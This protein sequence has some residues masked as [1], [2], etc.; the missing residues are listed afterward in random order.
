MNRPMPLP[1][2]NALFFVAI[3]PVLW[4]LVS[5]TALPATAQN[6]AR[7][8]ELIKKAKK[9]NESTDTRLQAKLDINRA[10]ALDPSNSEAWCQKACI[11]HIMEE[12]EQALPCI[13]RCLQL[14]PQGAYSWN[15]KATILSAMGKNQEAL[16]ASERSIKLENVPDMHIT[17]ATILRNL[18]KLEQA[19]SELDAVLKVQPGEVTAHA[20]RMGVASHTHHWQKV[21][22]DSTFLI[23]LKDEKPRNVL[24]HI[25]ARAE[26]YTELKQYDKAIADYLNELKVIPGNRQ[27][28]VGLIKAYRASGNL[29]AAKEQEKVLA[30]LDED[31]Q[32]PK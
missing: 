25:L 8:E 14:K 22:A 29:K 21:V 10:I 13:D 5:T 23:G 32:M 15:L 11:L 2:R 26:A 19:E 28:H 6:K 30:E 9:E 1:L 12:D 18:G 31:Y 7:A 3:G 16:E 17:H 27:L 20:R 4:T 24:S